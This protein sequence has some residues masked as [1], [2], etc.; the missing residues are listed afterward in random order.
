MFLHSFSVIIDQMSKSFW[1]KHQILHTHTHKYLFNCKSHGY[2]NNLIQEKYLATQ[3]LSTVQNACFL[4]SK[5]A[6]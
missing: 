4:N 1:I 2:V 3:L 5:S 6:Y